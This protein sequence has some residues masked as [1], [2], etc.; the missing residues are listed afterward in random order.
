MKKSLWV[1]GVGLLCAFSQSVSQQYIPD[2]N[3]VGLWH[4]NETG[5]TT[6]FDAAGNDDG[7]ISGTTPITGYFDSARSFTANIDHIRINYPPAYKVPNFTVE[8]WVN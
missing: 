5:G 3:T 2:S 4:L 7:L 8:A 6:A 1:I